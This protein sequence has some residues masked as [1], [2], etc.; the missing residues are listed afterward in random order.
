MTD[1][2]YPL[3]VRSEVPHVHNVPGQDTKGSSLKE[4]KHHKHPLPD[5][6]TEYAG[7]AGPTDDPTNP[8]VARD[9]L[10]EYGYIDG[11]IV[12]L[13]GRPITAIFIKPA[14]IPQQLGNGTATHGFVH[15]K[16]GTGPVRLPNVKPGPHTIDLIAGSTPS[17]GK[18]MW[19]LTV[20]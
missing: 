9:G 1:H 14:W 18:V 6:S 17:G 15:D 19:N 10:A 8:L 2:T 5:A 16:D 20:D 13:D 4:L 3:M 12:K 11:L 7:N